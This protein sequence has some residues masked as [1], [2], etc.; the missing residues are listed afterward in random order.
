MGV[1]IKANMRN[2]SGD[3]H[4]KCLNCSIINILVALLYSSFSRCHLWE[5]W[6]KYQRGESVLFIAIAFEY[7]IISKST[8]NIKNSQ[9]KYNKGENNS[10]L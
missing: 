4:V 10:R 5:N 9:L 8:K 2:P 1:D 6:V 3:G 7:T